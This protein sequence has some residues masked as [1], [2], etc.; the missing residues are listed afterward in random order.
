MTRK[1]GPS[2]VRPIQPLTGEDEGQQ[3]GGKDVEDIE[4]EEITCGQHEKPPV[5]VARDP[6]L[7]T[8]QEL[9]EHNATHL[10]HRSWC[11]VCTKA[12]GKEDAHKKGQTKGEKPIV[13]MDYKSFGENSGDDD[14]MTMIVIKDE[15]TGCIAAHVCQT[16]GST[17]QWVVDRLCDDVELFGHTEVILKSDGEPSIVQVQ[18]AIKDKRAH[19]TICQNSPAYNPQANRAAERAVQEVMG[20]IRA[21]KIGLQQRIN[22][23]IKTDWKI[24]EWIVELSTVLLNRCMIGK[25]GR[26]PYHRLMGKDSKKPI[27]E[28]GERVLAKIARGPQARR[29]QALKSR[30]EDAVWVGIAKK[31]NE[32]ILVLEGGGQAIRCRTIKRR[33]ADSRWSADKVAGIKAT[34]RAEPQ[35]A[36][37]AEVED[38]EGPQDREAGEGEGDK[39]TGGAAAAGVQAKRLQDYEVVA[40]NV[41]VLRGLPGMPRHVSWQER[42]CAYQGVP[43]SD[44][45]RDGGRPRGQP[46][47]QES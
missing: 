20:Q 21:M 3:H 39:P 17:D 43:G 4:A 16:K 37:R 18:S 41:W 23:E 9:E 10:P 45:D 30:W 25:D 7:P 5:K 46:A 32:H 35:G 38:R 42:A 40:G 12:R 31:S 8:A 1:R 29:K 14:K 22:A 13:S 26:T 34:P 33:P 11:P 44:R 27:V 19:N 6:G 36:G 15:M 28:L 2:R 24:L 47:D